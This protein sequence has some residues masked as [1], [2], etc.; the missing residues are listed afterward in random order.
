MTRLCGISSFNDYV[1]KE[2][3][4][5]IKDTTSQNNEII[6]GGR[7]FRCIACG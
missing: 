1:I 4:P 2:V 7:I 6:A 3:I 5:F